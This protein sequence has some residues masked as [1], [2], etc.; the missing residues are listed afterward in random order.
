[1]FLLGKKLFK[2]NV[3]AIG[4][5]LIYLFCPYALARARYHLS[6]ALIF[7]FPLLLYTLLNLK[8]NPKA[9]N[10]LKSF[11]ALLL[12]FSVH[13]YY[14]AMAL[15]LL[16][17]L[18]LCYLFIKL[19]K[20][21]KNSVIDY[22]FLKLCVLLAAL[23]III[24]LPIAYIQ[25]AMN[26]NNL[27]DT[28][29][30][31]GDLYT[32]AGHPWNYY[33][34]SLNSS[35]FG[36]TVEQSAKSKVL[37]TNIEEFV[38]FLGYTN[39]GLAL[40]ALF[41][42]FSRRRIKK[43]RDLTGE[44]QQGE[45]WLIPFA[46]L[47]GLVFFI[48]SLQPTIKIGN[49]TLYF[50]SWFI[51]KLVPGIRV[52]ARFG[53]V[54]FFSVTLLAGACIGFLDKALRPR[55]QA[56][57]YLVLVFLLIL[58]VSEFAEV[59][60]NPMQEMYSQEIEYSEIKALPAKS[61]VVE[62]PFVASD[63]IYNYSYLW[64]QLWHGKQMLNGYGLATEGE[65]LRNCVLNPCDP[66]TPGLLSY[67][68]ADYIL[69]HKDLFLKGSEYSYPHGAIKLG[70]IPAGYEILSEDDSHVLAKITQPRPDVVVIYDPKF[71]TVITP[72]FGNGWW[73][74]SEKKWVIEIDS[75]NERTVDIQFSI[76]SSRGERA[77]SVDLGQERKEAF[78]LDETS[79]QITIDQVHL[80]AGINH[81]DLQTSEEPTPYKDIFGGSDSKGV[82]FAM[83]FW[84]MR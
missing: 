16:A 18:A 29:R 48:F 7:I 20:G 10:K 38:L 74:G 54:V 58:A 24:S 50:P 33:T 36:T 56:L 66:K 25:T 79:R 21:L 43:A 28:G 5:G 68:G 23:A 15:L 59:N 82:C 35:F 69:I 53:A 61:V 17:L 42:W 22:S 51:F 41:L 31:Q 4:M 45:S 77:L 34:P 83:S 9:S 55:P 72:E 40:I 49:L 2:S 14:A 84:D 60:H 76:F 62:Y 13:P 11:L 52:Y 64:N 1:M 75:E 70:A 8:E 37:S 80:E 67:M 27:L 6:L 46:L 3:A 73:L 32:Y 12:A 47:A 30:Q 71:S 81:I 57:R 39:M 63:E 19:G 26:G 78:H 65:A 44:L